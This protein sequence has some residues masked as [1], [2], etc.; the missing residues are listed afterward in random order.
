MAAQEQGG[1]REEEQDEVTGAAGLV[2]AG[3]GVEHHRQQGRGVAHGPA[4]PE[5][6][7]APHPEGE[8]AGQGRGLAETLAAQQEEE[9]D[10]GDEDPEGRRDPRSNLER[11]GIGGHDERLERLGLGIAHQRHADPGPAVPERPVPLPQSPADLQPPGRDLVHQIPL[12]PQAGRV[13][14]RKMG[15]RQVDPQVVRAGGGC[16]R[17]KGPARGGPRGRGRRRRAPAAAP[18]RTSA[19]R[20]G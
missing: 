15:E 9:K 11:E 10:E 4:E 8:A 18:G 16:R 14:G 5:E 12:K 17:R 7:E 20:P 2:H 1:G 13:G 6:E 3:Q 19:S